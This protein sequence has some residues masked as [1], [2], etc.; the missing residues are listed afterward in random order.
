MTSHPTSAEVNLGT[1]M[2]VDA[3]DI[4]NPVALIDRH[5]DILVIEVSLV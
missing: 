5:P 2:L 4:D 1:R 3:L